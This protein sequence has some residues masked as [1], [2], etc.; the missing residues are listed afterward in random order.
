M[1]DDSTF[2]ENILVINRYDWGYYQSR[3]FDEIGEGPEEEG[4]SLAN[5]NSAG[6]VDIA[7]ARQY[8]ETR[9]KQRPSQRQPPGAGVWMYSPHA[10]Y[11]FGRF[12]F[13]H[14]RT[15]ARSF[16]FF[17]ADTKFTNTRLDGLDRSLRK[18]ETS[19][20]RFERRLR[21]GYDFF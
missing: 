18:N 14:P 11:M 15:A 19:D 8:V 7:E 16:L 13:D 1:N 21:E 17:S 2:Q 12:G 10:E 20:K 5:S 4:D 9:K 6:L 3:Y